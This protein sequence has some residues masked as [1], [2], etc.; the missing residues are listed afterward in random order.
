MTSKTTLQNVFSLLAVYLEILPDPLWV[1]G[2]KETP[3]KISYNIFLL[4]A[5]I[6]TSKTTLQNVFSLL[7]E[8][9]VLKKLS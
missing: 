1:G 8:A 2:T 3:A 6:I 5:K 7:A 4:Q 9:G